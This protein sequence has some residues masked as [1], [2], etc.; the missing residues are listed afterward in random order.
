MQ[1]EYACILVAIVM[2]FMLRY[3]AMGSSASRQEPY[4]QVDRQADRSRRMPCVLS[5]NCSCKLL[6]SVLLLLMLFLGVCSRTGGDARRLYRQLLTFSKFDVCVS[7]VKRTG[8][9]KQRQGKRKPSKKQA[10]R[11]HTCTEFHTIRHRERWVLT[12]KPLYD[13][14]P[15]QALLDFH[16]QVHVLQQGFLEPQVRELQVRF[17]ENVAHE[18]HIELVLID[19]LEDLSQDGLQPR[20][21]NIVEHGSLVAAASS[22]P[23]VLPSPVYSGGSLPF[24]R[25]TQQHSSSTSKGS[26]DVLP[27][28]RL[29]LQDCRPTMEAFLLRRQ[30]VVTPLFP[31]GIDEVASTVAT[32]A[33]CAVRVRV[34]RER[35]NA[36]C[37]RRS[38]PCFRGKNEIVLGRKPSLVLRTNGRTNNASTQKAGIHTN[39]SPPE[40]SKNVPYLV[41][42]KHE[43]CTLHTN[44]LLPYEETSYHRVVNVWTSAVGSNRQ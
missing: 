6:L 22:G 8:R 3:G 26:I 2:A 33:G 34:C 15:D 10:Q 16:R 19:R 32:R 40:F 30:V 21:Y 23:A 44:R 11:G 17:L 12:A 1:Y 31:C 7:S 43:T 35:S 13:Q 18:G 27:L 37:G 28:R 14:L 29:G 20:R 5:C 42:M 41:Q 9:P 4:V 39:S 38:V 24:S 36:S 25:H